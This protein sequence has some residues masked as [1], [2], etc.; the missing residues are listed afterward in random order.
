MK[1]LFSPSSLGLSNVCI[2]GLQSQMLWGFIFL[3]Y[4]PQ[5]MEPTLGLRPLTPPLCN[6][7]IPLVCG[8]PTQGIR[9]A[10]ITT[11]PVLFGSF[12]ISLVVEGLFW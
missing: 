8:L 6:G 11:P 4:D 5:V 7:N 3:A 1:S 12:F 2:T 10:Y 9:L